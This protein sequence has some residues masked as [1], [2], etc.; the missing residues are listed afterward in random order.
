MPSQQDP[1]DIETG[2]GKLP[3]DV[4]TA[5]TNLFAISSSS[6]LNSLSDLS[7]REIAISSVSSP[8]SGPAS[9]INLDP[10]AGPFFVGDS[11]ADAI[12]D[13]FRV[14]DYNT[15]AEIFN[16]QTKLYVQVTAISPATVG[17]GFYSGGLTLTITTPIPAGVAYYVFYGRR[18]TLGEIP[19]DATTFPAI[20]R[21]P[22]RV[23]FPEFKR[24][25]IA[26]TSIAEPL[27]IVTDGYP[28][29]LMAQW[30]AVLRGPQYN[31]A[32]A[33]AFSGSI[34]FVNLGRKK[35]VDATADQGLTGHQAA[36]FFNGYAKELLGTG[37]LAGANPLSR[38][39]P[40]LSALAISGSVIELAS[41][42][43]FRTATSSAIRPGIDMVEITRASGR[44]ETYVITAF[45][46]ANV[47]RATIRSLGGNLA[48]LSVA[49]VITCRWIRPSFYLG[50][51]NDWANVSAPERFHF[52]G[53]VN[54]STGPITDNSA[55]EV[56]QEPPFFGAS[57]NTPTGA[58]TA[59][60]SWD[61]V[62]FRWGG[63]NM[64]DPV[65]AEIG[66]RDI[67]GE[68]MG[69]GSLES[70]GGRIRGLLSNRADQQSVSANVTYTWNPHVYT[71]VTFLANTA[72]AAVLTIALDSAYTAQAGDTLT[73]FLNYTSTGIATTVVYPASFKFS[74]ADG[75]SPLVLGTVAKF[76]GT[77]SNG[78]FYFT[79]T[80]YV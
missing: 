5:A 13:L 10:S 51:D 60:G 52:R 48:A 41:T 32:P 26:P 57:R 33:T 43:F 15:D 69:D 67:K 66:R 55:V 63:F 74:G 64:V 45:D 3:I 27:N 77:Y 79:R 46:A 21:S 71:Q 37:Q 38:I 4:A 6:I 30:K 25:G 19:P 62:A 49:E 14:V 23:R 70:Y 75:S 47:R 40:A 35:N 61:L 50:G 24:T 58:D 80:D 59:R 2:P 28:D 17:T 1:S 34:G 18:T 56:A 12:G 36:G 76:E 42:D 8:S 31:F 20:R 78:N 22:D 44:I 54:V 7:N 16:P 73:F 39:N 72:S 65:V 53:F 29:P 68:L 11:G 9:S